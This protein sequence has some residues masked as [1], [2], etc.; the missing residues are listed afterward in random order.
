MILGVL[1]AEWEAGARARSAAIAIATAQVRG[2]PPCNRASED[3]T[4]GSPY[5]A[6]PHP[7]TDIPP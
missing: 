7:T 5:G 2:M 3:D 6:R 4:F 1:A